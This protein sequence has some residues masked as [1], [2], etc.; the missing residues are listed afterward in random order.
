MTSSL[1]YLLLQV[2]T[3][4]DPM[5][6][7]EVRCFARHLDCGEDQIAVHDLLS[8]APSRPRIDRTDVILIG[9]SGD[10]SV[11]TGGPWLAEA[12]DAMR[13]LFDLAKPTFAS[14]WGFQA[15][16]LALGGRVVT[17]LRRA[18]VGTT[19]LTL[20]T[21]GESDAVFGPLG[22]TFDAQMGHQDIVD[23][24]PEDAIPLASSDRVRNQA[25]TFPG[26]PIYGTQF[27]PELDLEAL[28]DRLRSYPDYIRS[29]TGLSYKDFV[30]DR[31]RP[32]LST[33]EL[34]R[35]FIRTI[36]S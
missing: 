19:R 9:G 35:R 18:E 31:C 1:R 4:D 15:L 26:K 10:F 11:V 28:L 13:L 32:S 21:E 8:G 5:A 2:R 24:L 20:T 16:S 27:H 22:T 33:Q 3:V 6:S 25:F 29:V 30:R 34:L 7:H 17:D 36:S 23:Q 14:C 12:L